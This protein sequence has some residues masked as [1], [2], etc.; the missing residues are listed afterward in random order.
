[1]SE[2]Q[3]Y[4]NM[5]VSKHE[6]L[7]ML[8]FLSLCGNVFF[9]TFLPQ[10]IYVITASI[11]V[12]LYLFK[13]NVNYR[14]SRWSINNMFIMIATFIL[15]F[16]AQYVVF[17]WNT[18]PG[19]INHI[20]KFIVGAGIIIYF[21]ERF[22]IVFFRTMSL[23]CMIALPLWIIQQFSGGI[24]GLSWSLG[25]TIWIYCY[26]TGE[27]IVRNCGFF[28]E[29][30]AMG[31][32]IALLTLL[33]FN[34]LTELYKNNKF[35]CLIIIATLLSTQSTGT[36][37]SFG[38]ILIIYLAVSMRSKWK[39]VL[40]PMCVCA[41]YFVYT[42]LDFLSEKV[43]S[44][45]ESTQ[46]LVWGEYS[47]TRSGTLYFDLYYIVKH[48]FIGNGLHERTRLADHPALAQMLS[49]GDVAAAGNGFSDTIAKW[50]LIYC[51]VYGWFFFRSNKGLD[52][53]RKLFFLLLVC[54]ILQGEQFMNFPLFLGI[55]LLRIV[56][57][58]KIINN[59]R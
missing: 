30:G 43:E 39:Y 57:D 32:Y 52:A 12:L 46:N 13:E 6:Y 19:M 45:N 1:M 31:G 4:L 50:G 58:K 20:C 54:V 47:S 35:K 41:A 16:L 48:P 38:T 8:Y 3:T 36:Y 49:Q 51:F 21:G 55:P 11:F 14:F 40:L 44:Q 15:L 9:G 59:K 26:R 56:N 28:W 24:G 5:E 37:M 22:R 27:D 17:G 34:D 18:V 53:K 33:F 2:N 42:S 10:T 25:K 23:L 29:P 7:I